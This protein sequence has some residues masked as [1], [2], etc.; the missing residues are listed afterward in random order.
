MSPVTEFIYGRR[1]NMHNF[2][3]L[4]TELYE[5]LLES[6]NSIYKMKKIDECKTILSM[7]GS[8]TFGSFYNK[9]YGNIKEKGVVYTPLELSYYMLEKTLKP[10]HLINNAYTRIIDPSCGVGNILIPCFSYIKKLYLENLEQ[11]NKNNKTNIKIEDID[12]HIIDYNIY[13]ID[14]DENALMVFQIDLYVHSKYI[15]P[16]KFLKRDFLLDYDSS[17]KYD[18][19]IGNPPYLGHKVIEKSYRNL[20]KEIYKDIYKDKGDLAFCFI[21]K[22]LSVLNLE[23]ELT[24][25]VSRYFMESLNGKQLRNYLSNNCSI[26]KIIDFYGIRPFKNTGIDPLIIFLRNKVEKENIIEVLRPEVIT[27]N[28]KDFSIDKIEFKSLEVNQD[29]LDSNTWILIGDQKRRILN[30]IE[31]KCTQSL[32]NL[33]DSKQGIITGC[34]KAFILSYDEALKYG[35]EEEILKPWIKSSGIKKNHV[36][37]AHNVLIYSNLIKNENQ[38]VRAVNYIAKYKSRLTQRRECIK[39]I[40]KWYELQWGR[41]K[42]IFESEKIIFPYKSSENRFALNNGSYFSADVYA[43]TI[44]QG[45]NITYE[46]LLQLLNSKVYEFYF[47]SFAKK[48]GGELYEYYPHNLLSLKIPSFS[49][50]VAINEQRL[51]KIFELTPEEINIIE[52][53]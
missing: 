45:S 16:V 3:S 11:I 1:I 20:I 25:V 23:G 7:D 27:R 31:S 36:E 2:I 5:I 34:D 15:N 53:K 52:N 10:E 35:I 13:G 40:R 48:L 18:I 44:K 26:R 4:L 50:D 32:K 38:Y 12:K 51:Y 28:K 46:L 33:C 14:I 8:D 22:A 30:K 39:G 47:K 41:E 9:L 21:K 24:L 43:L 37:K 29:S 42:K 49:S 6:K 17:I 19:V